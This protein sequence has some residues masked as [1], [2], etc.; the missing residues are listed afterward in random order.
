MSQHGTCFALFFFNSW[1]HYFADTGDYSS[2]N[3]GYGSYGDGYGD[4]WDGDSA[5]VAFG[6]V[7]KT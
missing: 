1:S 2:G 5:A 4:S 6:R 3:Y 7:V